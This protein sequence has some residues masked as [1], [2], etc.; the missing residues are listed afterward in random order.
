MAPTR[1]EGREATRG[2]VIAAADRLFQERGFDTTTIRDIAEASGV[3][4]GSVMAAGDKDDLLV[5]VFDALIAQG[6]VRPPAI[7]R[8]ESCGDRILILVGPFVALFTSRPDLSRVYASIQASGRKSS[9]LFTSLAALLIDEIGSTLAEHGC[10]PSEEVTPTAQAIYFA[11]IG[12][13]FSWTAHEVIDE[14]ELT[15]SLRATFAAICSCK[16]TLQ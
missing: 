10:T 9:P 16:E 8:A 12:T 11:Y 6:H 13:L 4:V 2:R 1:A 3:S 14:G 15:D 5:Q 7:S